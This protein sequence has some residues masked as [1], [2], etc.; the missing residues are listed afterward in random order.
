MGSVNT[1]ET[2]EGGDGAAQDGGGVRNQ[3]GKNGIGIY[4]DKREK[5]DQEKRYW[6]IWI[7]RENG[8]TKQRILNCGIRER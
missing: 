6:Y 8:I 7:K 4:M 2:R 1:R 3:T 5:S